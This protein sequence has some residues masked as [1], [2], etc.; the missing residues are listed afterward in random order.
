[1]S[2][3]ADIESLGRAAA[4][5]SA[6]IEALRRLPDDLAAGIRHLGFGRAMAPVEIGGGEWSV[7]DMVDQLE[8]LAYHD[9]ATA[10]C[11]MIAG[12][13]SLVAGSMTATWAEYIYGDP[14]VH[15][16]GFAAPVGRARAVDGGLE[17]SGQWQWGSG[18][19]HCTWIGGGCLIV[20]EDGKPA[21]LQDGTVAPFVFFPAEEVTLDDESWRVSGLKGTGSVDYRVD[22]A[23]V[24]DGRWV[25]IGVTPV[26]DRTLY[27]FSFLGALAVGIS[28]VS[29]GLA[30][31]AH[32]ELVDLAGGKRPQGSSKTLA[33]RA[34]VQD[35]IARA[36][37]GRRAA[38][39]LLDHAV[40]EAW[41]LADAGAAV[42]ARTRIA[43]RQAATHATSTAA[44]A[45]D[46]CYVAGGGAAIHE[47]SPLQRI[48][49][50]VH[51]A[52]QHAMVAPRMMEVVGRSLLGLPTEVGQ[53]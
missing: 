42:D 11:A 25:Q 21:P 16:G 52:T 15:T 33:E 13:T 7:A 20:D 19:H 1:M 8:R 28:A 5:R 4:D 41:S 6:E 26:V 45:V 36:D 37:A 32:D 38:R 30:R 23:V 29:L 35:S 18:T 48:F 44:D 43:L 34:V 51:V 3:P 2:T 31:R 9:G 50:D 53:L 39:H 47:R 14:E 40:R 27:R 24:P 10:W 17:A 49:R 46:A 22:R 12:T